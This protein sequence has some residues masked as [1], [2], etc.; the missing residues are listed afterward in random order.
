[1]SK[2]QTRL[3]LLLSVSLATAIMLLFLWAINLNQ[4]SELRVV[5]NRYLLI[6][7]SFTLLTFAGFFLKGRV[8]DE[9]GELQRVRI[10]IMTTVVLLVAQIIFAF[11]NYAY[12][13]LTNTFETFD[14]AQ[15][16]YED[17][18]GEFFQNDAR[19]LSASGTEI[20]TAL[21]DGL[22]EH[23]EFSAA[24]IASDDGRVLYASDPALEGKTLADDPLHWYSYPL[25]AKNIVLRLQVSTAHQ[26]QSSNAILSELLTIMA[27][28]IFLTIEL[29]LFFLKYIS[30]RSTPPEQ[31]EGKRPLTAL[32]YVRQIAFLFYFAS[33][34]TSS[35]LSVYARS[36]GG[37]LFGLSGNVL[38]AVPQSAETLLTCVAILFTAALIEKR[39][40]KMPF[41]GGLAF[42]AVGTFGSALA[43][44]I[45]L[46][47]L[48][49][50]VV[51]L[52]YGFCWMTLR[53]FALFGRNEQE[54]SE[55]FSLLNAG[56]YAGINCGSVLGSILAERLGYTL[57]F[58]LSAVFTLLCA[59][60]ITRMENAVYSA[61]A[62]ES[63]TAEAKVGTPKQWAV[64]V[65]FLILMIA[66]ACISG[67]FLSYYLPLYFTDIGRSVADVGRAK[68]LYGILIIYIGPMLA[69]KLAASNRPWLWNF[70]YILLIGSAF[71][72]FGFFG[73]L[74][75]AFFAVFILGF[76]DS[77]GFVAQNNYFLALPLVRR[78]GESK[79]LSMLSLIK[80]L[81]EMVGPIVFG[82]AISGADTSGVL[83]IGVVCAAA[84][85]LFVGSLR[86]TREKKA[87]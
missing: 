69:Q 81:L 61:P 12:R 47:V 83:L 65:L 28:S 26:R 31:I 74:A 76:S 33:Q 52:G 43:P 9:N 42:V 21:T 46:Y 15:T 57:V 75:A 66:P 62:P 20:R 4:P 56:L 32:R 86:I 73:G 44:N 77:F 80:K 41:L 29:M 58:S 6:V 45:A 84:A 40:W 38:A 63:S 2:K 82:L 25:P 79:S 39:G 10:L 55:G 78:L 87:V 13:Q 16:F 54:K 3:L 49:R 5:L 59:L 53:N 70:A 7:G 60:V 35:F 36:L 72:F 48:S 23:A 68:L 8:F 17:F 51:G 64:F 34:M 30:D 37:S 1:M 24:A 71:L 50:A 19:T 14:A 22:K 27:A 85:L 11:A 18:S 67:S